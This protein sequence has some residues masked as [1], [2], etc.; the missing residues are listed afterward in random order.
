MGKHIYLN[1]DNEAFLKTVNSKIYVDK[2]NL[3]SFTNDVIETD[4]AYICNSRP[5][6]FGKSVTANMLTAYYSKG[7]DSKELFSKYA[8]SKSN[9]FERY[10]NK[11]DVIHFDVQSFIQPG[12]EVNN[13]VNIIQSTIIDEL[14]EEYPNTI[15]EKSLSLKDA[16]TDVYNKTGNQ[17]VIIIDE[18]DTLIRN[19]GN[20]VDLQNEYINFLRS[21]FKG[22]QPTRY[23]AL[24]YLTG[25]LP[26]IKDKTQSA[27]NNFNEYTML[28]SNGMSS[29]IGFIEEEV[30]ELA[31]QFDRNFEDVRRWYDGYLLDT[32]HVYNP[33]A[34]V[35]VMIN[36]NYQS[37]WS[38]TGS[39]ESIRKYI[40]MNFDGLKESIMMMLSGID[41]PVNT[42][43]YQNDMVSFKNKD[44]ILT[45]LIHL[46]YLAYNQKKKTA[47]IPNEE[48][49]QEFDNA[50]ND[51]DFDGVVKMINDSE[52]LMEATLNKESQFVA[53]CIEKVHDE[54]ASFIKY[55]DENS[56][57]S[58]VSMAY[59]AAK[60]YYYNPI[61][62]FQGGRGYADIVYIP[63]VEY[64]YK[65]PALVFE[66]KWDKSASIAIQQIKDR[67]YPSSLQQ[68]T[69]NILLIGIN[70]NTKDKKHSC[71]IE[72]YKK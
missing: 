32:Y 43:T 19:D 71:L 16:L 2:T 10:L 14:K 41:V 29:Y 39:Y 50:V 1:P 56:L 27:L 66:L 57:A 5:R 18:W 69:G 13:L 22:P 65:Y 3:I 67:N 59:I 36:G 11:Y 53:E 58:V 45:M 38:N 33:R 63:K 54:Q 20:D 6:R 30:K 60:N 55:H 25:I 64:L 49:R 47:Y 8:I 61:H 68:Y 23:I 26:I 9:D 7:C 51:S 42:N 31:L 28:S 35:G 70:Y 37:Y 4:Q 46:G 40:M 52:T 24:A 15:Q 62:E 34:V 48:I 72:E 17:F 12:V 21:L 44:Q